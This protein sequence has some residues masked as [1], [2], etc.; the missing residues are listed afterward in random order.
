VIL[1]HD[2]WQRRFGGA[3][4]V[5]GRVMHVNGVAV[6]VVGVAATGFAGVS[7]LAHAWIPATLAPRVSYADYLTTNQN[8]ITVVGRL[9]P[10]VS[11]DVARAEMAA[12][13]DRIHAEEPSEADTP[14]DR[15]SA[16]LMTLNEARV[17]VITRR[18]LLLLSGA[19]GLL[20]VISCA[21]VASLLLGRAARRRREIAIRLAI[22]ADRGTVVRQ[23]L[24][25][26]GLIAGVSGLLGLVTAAW[27]IGVLRIPP[28]LSRGRNFYGAV[29]EFAT[30]ALDWRV[31]AF[32]AF[33]C[34]CTVL[35]FGLVPALRATRTDLVA[36]L[37]SGGAFTDTGPR[38]LGLR[39]MAV[40]AQVALAV[41]L[42]VSCGLLLTSYSRLRDTRL[43]FEPS[44]LLTFMILPSEVR[45]PPAAAP[46]LLEAMLE[47]IHQV[48]GVA[49]ATVDGC[50]PLSTQCAN[51]PLHIVGRP[52]SDPAQAPSVLRHY[53]APSHFDALGIPLVRGRVLDANDRAGRPRVVVINEAAAERFW[54][55]EDPIGRR[56][57]FDGAP[58]FGSPDSSAQ[59]VGIVRNVAYQPLEERPI[60]PDFFTAFAQFTYPSR[61]VLV[62]TQLEPM[63]LV[64]AIAAAVRR[65]DPD[66]A[67]FDVQTMESRASL[68]WSKLAFQT[69]LFVV[70]GSIALALAVTGVYAVTAAFVSSRMRDIG[71]RIAIGANAL[72]VARDSVATTA[73]LGLAGGAVGLFGALAISR[74]MRATLYET[75]PLDAG[76]Y[77]VAGL[78][79]ITAF[80]AASYI[81]VR[82][83]LRVNP[84]DVLRNE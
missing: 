55:D 32:T 72:Q 30:P 7:G 75:S 54:P 16:A 59:I 13:G 23:L 52:W 69:A 2:L 58:A 46:D 80:V 40:A 5:L 20:L 70:I 33:V 62:R 24:V 57:W 48:P 38:R 76:V 19:V 44:N 79:L 27:G 11:A 8:F 15:F 66:L 18:A 28:T 10:G 74:I 29:G 67:L 26:S 37:K 3:P 50:A 17:D 68:S 39:E 61:M 49:A 81:P 36:D 45:Y 83:A 31:L 60:Q 34:A 56:V 43:G 4:D 82:R 77:A 41:V 42:I 35:L 25:E 63:S 65:A 9:R 53:V 84:V 71:I 1:G 22:G 51:A 21:N 14:Q 47:L 73:R 6:T 12:V 78:V 64:P